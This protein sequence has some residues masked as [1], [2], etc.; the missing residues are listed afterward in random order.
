MYLLMNWL[1]TREQIHENQGPQFARNYILAK[2]QKRDEHGASFQSSPKKK[3]YAHHKTHLHTMKVYN[4]R[5]FSLIIEVSLKF[6][7]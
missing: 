1:S 2:E 4:T 3:P 6:C 7:S 5:P